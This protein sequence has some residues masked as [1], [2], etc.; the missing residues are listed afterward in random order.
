[1]C[2]GVKT[3][4]NNRVELCDTQALMIEG[5]VVKVALMMLMKHPR[6]MDSLDLASE[7]R[8]WGACMRWWHIRY[9]DC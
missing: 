8:A 1:M 7:S 2:S 9:L 5:V 6:T 4:W 3:G